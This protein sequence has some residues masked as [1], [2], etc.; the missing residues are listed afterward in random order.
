MLIISISG[1]LLSC[2][3]YVLLWYNV[4][5]DI[6]YKNGLSRSSMLQ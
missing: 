4:C 6:N 5:G 3:W 2:L 1:G